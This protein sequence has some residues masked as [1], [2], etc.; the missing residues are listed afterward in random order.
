MHIKD[1][2]HKIVCF[3]KDNVFVT[4]LR[5]TIE[6]RVF[7]RSSKLNSFILTFIHRLQ[8]QLKRMLNMCWYFLICSQ[9]ILL[10]FSLLLIISINIAML[11]ESNGFFWI[12]CDNG[13][14]INDT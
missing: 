11:N 4:L 5:Y 2:L 8:K 6:A 1:K 12:D 10:S 14:H 3:P 9:Y 13:D 7:N